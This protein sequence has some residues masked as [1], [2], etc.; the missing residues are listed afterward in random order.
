M[1]RLA[2]RLP[3]LLPAPPAFVACPLPALVPAGQV[4][5][6]LAVYRLA[7]ERTQAQLAPRRPAG[8]PAF[9]AN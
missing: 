1:N 2:N 4:A 9:S 8:V 7:A 3:A 6:V 5:Q